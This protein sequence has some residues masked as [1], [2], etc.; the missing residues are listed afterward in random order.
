MNP[1]DIT[2]LADRLESVLSWPEAD[3]A[4]LTL[5]IAAE[6]RTLAQ[7]GEAG[8]VAECAHTEILTVGTQSVCEQYGRD[9][10]PANPPEAGVTIAKCESGDQ[11]C[12][13]A[14]FEDDGGTLLCR[15]CW[16]QLEPETKTQ[17]RAREVGLS[18]VAPQ[19]EDAER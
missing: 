7:Q 13:P 3:R 17:R 4:R 2:R 6:L 10:H 9:P 19:P 5:N 1:D 11:N 16:G 8:G 12:G 14:E 15:S 18:V